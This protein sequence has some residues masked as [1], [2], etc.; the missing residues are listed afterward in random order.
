MAAR[1]DLRRRRLGRPDRVRL[2]RRRLQHRQARPR[3]DRPRRR[4]GRARHLHVVHG[5][6]TATPRHVLGPT[7]KVMPD[8]C[9]WIW[10]RPNRS[11]STEGRS[12]PCRCGHSEHYGYGGVGHLGGCRPRGAQVPIGERSPS[13][14][15]GTEHGRTTR[16]M[17]ELRFDGKTVIVTGGGRGFGRHHALEFARRGASVVVAEYGMALDGTGWT[18]PIRRGRRDP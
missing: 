6:L 7:R 10:C 15:T 8:R 17:D 9:R 2:H 13:V 4:L 12:G 14:R 16:S 18:E 3:G 5:E 11:P 1:P